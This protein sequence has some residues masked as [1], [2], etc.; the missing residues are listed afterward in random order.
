M[1]KKPTSVTLDEDLAEQLAADESVNLS[2]LVNKLLHQ[3]MN[4]DASELAMLELR[5]GQL[6]SDV[7]T[8][9]SN[10]ETKRAELERVQE[11]LGA[12]RD[13]QQDQRSETIDE[14]FNTFDS[15]HPPDLTTENPHVERFADRLGIT[16]ADLLEAY[17]E[18]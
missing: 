18:R 15:I 4:G 7:E 10:L 11:R 3:Y 13:E 5:E 12:V 1:S 14:A 2:G 16:P 6:Q 17:Y 8:L 9:E